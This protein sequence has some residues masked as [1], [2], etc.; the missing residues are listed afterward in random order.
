M[1]WPSW[2]FPPTPPGIRVRTKAVRHNCM[3]TGSPSE[4]DS[5]SRRDQRWGQPGLLKLTITT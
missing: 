1:G 5:L 4:A 3:F 2:A